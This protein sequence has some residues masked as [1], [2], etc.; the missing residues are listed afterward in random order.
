MPASKNNEVVMEAEKHVDR[1][2]ATDES[3]GM[4]KQRID[5]VSMATTNRKVHPEVT[6]LA[7]FQIKGESF[8]SKLYTSVS[9]LSNQYV[10]A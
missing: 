4:E 7:S 1:I 8:L 10:A 3:C 2:T 9:E 6:S 5:E